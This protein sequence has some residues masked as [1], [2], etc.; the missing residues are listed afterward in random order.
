MSKLRVQS[1]AVSLDGYGAGPDQDLQNPLGVG[2]MELMEW[3]FPTRVWQNMYGDTDG[4]T[5]IDNGI[6]EL[7][8]SGIGA[9]IL[10]RNMFGPIRGPWPD[11]SWQGW[12]GDEP[13]Y[14]TP[15]YVLTHH[16]RAPIQMKGGT[17]FHFVTEGI[18]AA[19]EQAKAAAGGL[20]VRLGGGVATLR[21]Y[22]QAGLVDEMHLALRPVLLGNGENLWEGLDLRQLGYHCERYV[23]GERAMH[24]FFKRE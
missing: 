13:P 2:G 22:L 17:E 14:H 15:V 5:G 18:H 7:G 21:Q 9:W 3:F 11:L 24:V 6:A 16:A 8:F 12:W 23:A 4:E 10:G 20:D 1:F 19:L